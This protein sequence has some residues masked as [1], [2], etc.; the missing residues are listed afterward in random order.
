MTRTTILEKSISVLI[1]P[2]WENDDKGK[3]LEG[4]SSK[5]LQR[6]SFNI[7][8]RIRFTGMEIDLLAKHKPSGDQIYVEHE[9]RPFKI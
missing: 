2:S 3:Y 5:I 7:I 1:P 4:L 6:Q 8:E 9:F